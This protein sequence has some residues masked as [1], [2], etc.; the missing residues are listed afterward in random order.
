MIAGVDFTAIAVTFVCHDGNKNFLMHK[1]SQHTRDE[2]GKWDWGGGKLEYGETIEE[3]L[4][5]ELFEEYG[6]RGVVELT[7]PPLTYFGQEG[8]VKT[9]WIALGHLIRVDRN[10][11]KNNE[12]RS[13]DEIGWF[14]LDALPQ[15]LHRGVEMDIQTY[16]PLI[17]Q[18]LKL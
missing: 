10:E 11:V 2:Q 18:F 15:P 5:R 1:R 12:P 9:H 14:A 7:F 13:I 4:Q 17:K 6:C 3:A 16:R 8:N